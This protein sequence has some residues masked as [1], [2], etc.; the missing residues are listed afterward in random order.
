[1]RPKAWIFYPE[2]QAEI[3]ALS[4]GLGVSEIVARI[5]INR[6]IRDIEEGN[7]FLRPQLSDLYDPNLM[8]GVEEA[9]ERIRK[10]VSHREKILIYGD[11]DADGV[12]STSLM[13]HFFK[14]INA[15]VTH[16]I[17]DRIHE[18][19]SF[20]PRGLKAILEQKA[21]L[22]ISVDNGI[23]SCEEVAYLR[24][25][26]VDV[27][28]TDH[29]EP[30]EVL[31]EAN[32]IIDPKCKHCPYPFKQL[33][34]V[35]VAFKTVWGVAQHLSR[36]KKVSPEF[37]QFLLDSLAWVA[38]GTITDLVPLVGENRIFANYG[39]PAIQ[40]STNPGMR[41]LCDMIGASQQ[42]ASENTGP[43]QRLT[44]EDVSFRIGPRINAAGR[45]GRVEVAVNLFSTDSYQEALRLASLL[46]DMN[47]ERQSIEKA[48]FSEVVARVH[49]TE[50]D[51]IIAGDRDWHAGVIGIVAS[52]L[53]EEYGKPAILLAFGD[54]KG[55]GS[56]RSIPGFDI[57]Q[58]LH[59]CEDLLDTYGGHASAGGLQIQR[60][61][62]D[63]FKERI[64]EYLKDSLPD[65]EFKAKL[66]IDCEIHLAALSHRLLSQIDKLRPFGEA[67]PVPIFASS[68]L[69]LARP[70]NKVGRDSS[71]LSFILRQGPAT[72]K[73]IA[74]GR[75]DDCDRLNQAPTFA[76]AYTPR[77]NFF[78]GRSNLELD[79]KDILFDESL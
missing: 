48:I 3:S 19:Y 67:N 55:R 42:M 38:L 43:V 70:A 47:R 34:G 77:M 41:A 6:G 75:G 16:Y 22:V 37:R 61:N 5:L 12:T 63:V 66:N 39:L 23:N 28:I 59:H 7:A 18:G 35:G 21:K 68:G 74:F 62:V 44:S 11:F 10:A 76:L 25:N 50:D 1:M 54:K 57:Y 60:A 46:D 78:N 13:L 30:P 79:V 51:L 4:S 36:S 32:A 64:S 26:G 31:P 20:T 29:H 72:Y 56:C 17:P 9:A 45:M 73:A 15:S 14:C 71:H 65:E 24:Q 53:V 8:A 49:G 27:I 52:K 40:N 2:N 33:S 58:A 69:K